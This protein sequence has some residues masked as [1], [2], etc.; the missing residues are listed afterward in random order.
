M[1]SFGALDASSIFALP[2]RKVRVY[3]G[4]PIDVA[5]IIAKCRVRKRQRNVACI[6]LFFGFN[7]RVQQ[8]AGTLQRF[9]TFEKS[10]PRG[11]PQ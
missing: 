2:G 9:P 11:R 5:P 6:F 10:G 1:F 3:V 4:E 8:S 7:A